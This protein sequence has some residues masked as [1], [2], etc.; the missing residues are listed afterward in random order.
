M[1]GKTTTLA[2]LSHMWKLKKLAGTGTALGRSIA[3][4]TTRFNKV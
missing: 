4:N 2:W 3:D 1:R